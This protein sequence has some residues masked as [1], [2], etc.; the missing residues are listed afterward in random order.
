VNL[1]AIA[2][3]QMV[4]KLKQGEIDG[5]CVGEP[6]NT[7]AIQEGIGFVIATDLDIWAGN[8]EKVLGM[9]EAWQKQYPNTCLAIVKAIL[10]A[11]DYCDEPRHREEIVDLLSQS[12]YLNIPPQYLHPGLVGPFVRGDNNPAQN[13]PRFHQFHLDNTNCPGRVEGLWILSQLARWGIAPFPKNRLEVLERVR[14]VDLF[15]EAS[16]QLKIVGIEPDRAAFKLF[17][18][19]LFNPD[20]PLEYIESETFRCDRIKIEDIELDPPLVAR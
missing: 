11:C 8:P 7:Q 18:G 17:D 3:P 19:K 10:A 9:T 4:T 12:Q 6:W 20:L 16:Q 13:L 5:F 14:R 2:P 1:I 15:L